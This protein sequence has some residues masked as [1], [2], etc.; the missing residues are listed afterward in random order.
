MR[1]IDYAAF[2]RDIGMFEGLL[3]LPWG[4]DDRGAAKED[5]QAF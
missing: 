4:I 2:R 3:K 5:W 1:A